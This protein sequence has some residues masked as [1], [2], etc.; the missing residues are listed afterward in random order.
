MS[1]KVGN[2]TTKG[3]RLKNDSMD[4]KKLTDKQE[5]FCQEYMVDLNGTQAAIRA[6]YSED[7]AKTIAGQNLSKLIIQERLSEL[8]K[9]RSEKVEI[10]AEMVVKELKSIA[11]SRVIDYWQGD[12]FG[13]SFVLTP[14]A[15]EDMPEEAKSAISSIEQNIDKDGNI[16]FK[17]R[18]WDKMK[19][20]EMLCKHLG[21][22]AET[23]NVKFDN[24]EMIKK[25]AEEI[26][27]KE[28]NAD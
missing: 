21:I 23:F 7:T 8:K 25:V 17:I 26:M 19:S 11:F 1:L 10:S 6:G 9:S 18:L 24:P 13:R 2:L 16:T 5:M 12:T 15:F 3:S 14:K 20:L 4:K 22:T 27:E 28:E